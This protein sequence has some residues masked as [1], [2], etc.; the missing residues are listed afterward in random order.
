MPRRGRGEGT[1]VRR[2]DGRW[3]GQIMVGYGPD[4]KPRRL[5]VY[6]QTRQEVAAKLAE[7][8]AQRHKGLLPEPTETPSGSGPRVAGT[9][10]ARGAPQNPHPLP[11]RAGLRPPL[12]QG[13]QGP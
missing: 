13:P 12:P 2:P 5:T 4:G 7:L 11:G 6:G 8:A 9:E 1:I 10:G 3:M